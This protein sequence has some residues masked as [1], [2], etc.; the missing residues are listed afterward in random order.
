MIIKGDVLITVRALHFVY[1]W[2]VI[3]YYTS[4]PFS[5]FDIWKLHESTFP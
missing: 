4:N 1:H 5:P 3:L 2:H